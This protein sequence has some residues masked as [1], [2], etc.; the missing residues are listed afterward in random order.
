ML[1]I[2]KSYLNNRHFADDIAIIASKDTAAEVSQVMQNKIVKTKRWLRKWKMKVNTAKSKHVTLA[3]RRGDCPAVFLNNT[4][5]PHCDSAKYFGL[6]INR[7]L[8]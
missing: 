4:Q 3:L 8:T 6:H 1:H 5:I 2:L 7:R